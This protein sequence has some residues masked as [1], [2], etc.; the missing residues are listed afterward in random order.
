MR[1]VS[2]ILLAAIG[3]CLGI[4]AVGQSILLPRVFCA[5]PQA[6]SA[7]K[8]KFASMDPTLRPAFTRLL[9]EANKTL[10]ARPHSVMEKKQLPPS[11]DKHD[12]MSQAPYFWKDTN[13]PDGKYVRHDG[14]RNPESGQDSDANRLANVCSSVS[15]L[16]LAYY[17]TDD[18][19]YAK[20]SAEL[21]RVFFLNAD[22]KMNPNLNYGQG[23]PGETEGRPAGLISARGLVDMMDGLGLLEKSDS[24]TIADRQAMRAWL[25]QYF[26]W[27]TTSDIGLG[28]LKAKNNHGTFCND[29]AAAIALFLGKVDYAR[30]LVLQATNRLDSQIETDGRQPLELVRTKSFG[31]SA[32]NLRALIDLAS[33]G[34]NVGV[35]LWHYKSAKGVGI[36]DAVAF[37]A[38]YADTKKQWPFEQIHGYDHS[39]LADVLLRAGAV[40]SQPN[41]TGP[42]QQFTYREIVPIRCRL[43]FKTADVKLPEPQPGQESEDAVEGM[44]D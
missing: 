16:A 3:C 12:Y 13:S 15:T 31:Y 27:L 4:T 10:E 33:I 8:Q 6:L 5:D 28:E 17:F 29:Q 32:F 22:T 19:K 24:W 18:E 2:V 23:I 14:E 44:D 36:C 21:L 37:M 30:S 9:D 25:E 39:P 1:P 43:L 34:Q 26:K 7:A 20:K 41:I 35:D 42:L 40:Y 11:G 38:P